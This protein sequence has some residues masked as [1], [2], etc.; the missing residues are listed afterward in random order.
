LMACYQPFE[1]AALSCQ[2][3]IRDHAIRVIGH[4]AAP[5]SATSGGR[6]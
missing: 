2:H 6:S 3:G 1:G 5:C 4:L